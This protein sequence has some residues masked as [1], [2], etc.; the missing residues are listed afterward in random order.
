LRFPEDEA[1]LYRRFVVREERKV[2]SD[3]VLKIDGRLWE[4]PRGLADRRTEVIR[5]VL[6]DRFW[7]VHEGRVV[8]LAELDPHANA[9]ERRG[10]SAYIRPVASEGVPDTAATLAYRQ[11][12]SPL[13]DA[14]G[15]YYPADDPTA[16]EEEQT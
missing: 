16:P 5:H 10:V 4:A 15:A 12:F 11:D 14:E 6:D 8:E 1:D 9:T 13:V 3:H 7:V 2:S